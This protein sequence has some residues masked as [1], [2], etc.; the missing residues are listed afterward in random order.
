MAKLSESTKS[1]K[2][3]RAYVLKHQGCWDQNLSWVEFSY[4]N[5]YQDCLK[6]AP[7]KVLYGQQCRTPLNW[8]KP[9][10]KVKLGPDLIEEAEATVRHIQDNLTT[11]KSRQETYAKMRC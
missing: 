6:M 8:T 4:I 1:L 3:L 9:S 7:F 11:A 10:E 2:I 5:S